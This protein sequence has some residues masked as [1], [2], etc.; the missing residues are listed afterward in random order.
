MS[1]TQIITDE[2]FNHAR[3]EA[4]A[5][6]TALTLTSNKAASATITMNA[7]GATFFYH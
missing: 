3:M 2:E 4:Q 7:H 1:E 5:A 6:L